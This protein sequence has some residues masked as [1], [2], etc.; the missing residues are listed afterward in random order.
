MLSGLSVAL[1]SQPRLR[2]LA[3]ARFVSVLGSAF[4][5]IAVS[6]GVLALPGATP[7]DLS[8][9]LACQALPQL[10]FVLWGGVLGDRVRSRFRLVSVT[11]SAAAACWAGLAVLFAA[12]G[13]IWLIAL[14]AALGG[15]TRGLFSPALEGVVVDVIEDK[16]DR[17]QANAL[18]KVSTNTARLLGMTLAGVVVSLLGPALALALDALSFAACAALF[19]ALGRRTPDRPVRYKSSALRDLREGWREFV[20]HEWLWVTTGQLAF[21]LAV[22]NAVAGLLGPMLAKAYLGGAWAWALVMVAQVVGQVGGAGWAGRLRPARPMLLATVCTAGAALP[23]LLLAVRAPL[24]LVLAGALAYGV[25][26]DVTMVLWRT[27]LQRE[28]PQEAIS[29]VSSIDLLGCLAL[30]PAGLAVAGPLAAVYGPGAIALGSAG[31]V[32]VAVGLALLSRDI[33]TLPGDPKPQQEM[34]PAAASAA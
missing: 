20:A 31:L 33:R 3:A 11:E 10:I 6:F 28:V 34:A 23:P 17:Q 29:R 22:V 2:L 4:G 13:P 21:V 24:L 15:V 25:M 7:G 5:P 18:L 8:L 9:V 1:L 26:W 12:G 27:C 32:V 16:A 30:A 14:L 19:T